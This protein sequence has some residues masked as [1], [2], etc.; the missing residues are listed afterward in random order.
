MSKL[1]VFIDGSWLYKASGPGYIL[2]SKT[3]NPEQ[4]VRIDFDRL[5]MVLLDHARGHDPTCT[6][7]GERYLSTSVFTLPPDFDSWPQR[8]PAIQTAHVEQ[9]K[10]GVYAR[11]RFVESARVAGYS[12]VGVYRPPIKHWILEKLISG[13]YHEKQ[14]DTTVVALLVR[15]AIL[16]PDDYHCVVT[17]DSDILPAI[18]L[19]HAEYSKNVFLAS[20]HPDELKAE[21]RQTAFSLN[22]FEFRIPPLYLQDNVFEILQGENVYE[23]EHCLKVFTRLRAIPTHARAC[24]A[25][26]HN[27]RA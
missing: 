23:C 19:A 7:L 24:C 4:G 9:T 17:G 10:R 16:K 21:H 2:A 15:A 20:T 26:C 1:N 14:V 27:Q 13:R 5:D 22:N 11:N 3:E 18:R 25:V 12:D 8:Y 6:E